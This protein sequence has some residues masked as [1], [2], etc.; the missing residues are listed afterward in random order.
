MKSRYIQLALLVFVVLPINSWGQ[1]KFKVEPVSPQ[2]QQDNAGLKGYAPDEPPGLADGVADQR[3]Q[4]WRDTVKWLAPWVI[5]FSL[6]LFL[7]QFVT[8]WKS[9]SYWT[10]QQF[11]AFT[12]T[13]IIFAGV[14]LIVIGWSDQQL[15]P[16]MGLLGTIAGY[17]LGADRPRM[18]TENDIEHHHQS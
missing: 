12:L 15:A 4:I 3:H 6:L 9:K 2:I 1:D 14:F 5:I 8:M 7:G 17:I 18:T 11:K 10:D 13:L 16:M